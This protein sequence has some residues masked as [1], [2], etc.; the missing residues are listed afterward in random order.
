MM[1]KY[2]PLTTKDT[3]DTKGHYK[4]FVYFESLVVKGFQGKA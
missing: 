1:R 4:S 2:K 3:K